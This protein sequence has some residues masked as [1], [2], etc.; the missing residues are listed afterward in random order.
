MNTQRRLSVRERWMIGGV[1]LATG[2]LA[3]VVVVALLVSGHSTGGGCIDVTIPY[4]IGGQEFYQCG[5]TA[6]RTCRSVGQPGG[7]VGR[8]GRAVAVECRK[9]H[10]PVGRPGQAGG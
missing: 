1:L 10:L 4:S 3:A 5:A 2:A 6:R 9:T 8:A 7:F